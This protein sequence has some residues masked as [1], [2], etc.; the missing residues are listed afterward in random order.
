MRK[1]GQGESLVSYPD[2]PSTT[3]IIHP[4]LQPMTETFNADGPSSVP[5]ESPAGDSVNEAFAQFIEAEKAGRYRDAGRARKALYA[6]GWLVCPRP[7]GRASRDSM[8]DPAPSPAPHAQQSRG[9]AH[10]GPGSETL[11]SR[12]HQPLKTLEQPPCGSIPT[13]RIPR[14]LRAVHP[15]PAGSWQQC[16]AMGVALCSVT[17][18]ARQAIP[19]WALLAGSVG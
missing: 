19:M 5:S 8:S 17:V 6:L 1:G 16:R 4:E 12:A 13:T 18:W 2:L 10:G 11:S 14:G 7:C 15:T 3:Q 9:K